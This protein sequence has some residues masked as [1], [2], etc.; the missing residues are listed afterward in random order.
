MS[1]V[2]LGLMIRL[3]F[4]NGWS[5]NKIIGFV[6]QARNMNEGTRAMSAQMRASHE[7][8]GNPPPTPSEPFSP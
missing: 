4:F 1:V 2:D 5:R 3:F 6:S 7:A 8:D